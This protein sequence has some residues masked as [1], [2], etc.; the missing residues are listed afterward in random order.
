MSATILSGKIVREYRLPSLIERVR[1]L[2]YIPKLAIIQIGDR[3]DSTAFISM[4]KSFAVRIGVQIE[5]IHFTAKVSQGEL[6]D[7]ISECNSDPSIQ[8]IIVQLPMP[9]HLDRDY[10]IEMIDPKKDIDG[11]T[12]TNQKKLA[13]NDPTAIIPATARAVLE[14]LEYYKIDLKHG[15]HQ[16]GLSDSKK[17]TIIG[18]SK[19]VGTPMAWVCRHAGA[20]VIVCHSKTEDLAHETLQADIVICAVGKVGLIQAKHVKHGQVVIDVGINKILMT[21]ND[22]RHITG[23]TYSIVGDVDFDTVK[24]IV[25]AITPVPGGVGPMTVLCLFENLIDV[26]M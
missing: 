12:T 17:V 18:R 13:E 4:K 24:E 20:E 1:Q 23:N 19:L 5:H 3:P 7:K 9:E 10:I 21:D 8:G 22:T 11:L 26:C 6:V 15:T 16:Q 25:S 14:L 2:S